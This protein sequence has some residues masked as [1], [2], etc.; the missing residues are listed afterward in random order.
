MDLIALR[1]IAG[2]V[3]LVLL[4]AGFYSEPWL[5]V[6]DAPLTALAARFGFGH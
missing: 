3:I 1:W 4:G 5:E 2:V 6:T